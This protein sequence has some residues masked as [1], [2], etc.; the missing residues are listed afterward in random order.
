[1][2]RGNP[3]LWSTVMAIPFVIAGLWLYIGKTGY[4]STVGLP[5][6][7]FAIFISAVGTYV[8]YVGAPNQPE[9]QEGDELIVSRHPTQRVAL[10]KIV[11]SVPFLLL[12][13]YLFFYTIYPYVYPTVAFL[14]GLYLF[15]GG[16]HTYWTN[17]LT[18]Y[19]V[20]SERVI[21][22]YRLVSLVRQEVPLQKVRGV[23]ERKSVIET[24]VGLGNVRVASGEGRS[25]EIIMKDMGRSEQFASKVRNAVSAEQK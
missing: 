20:T 12:T 6:L 16:L 13:V 25:L 14:A 19:Y 9:L 23:Q 8:H 21:K 2:S 3:R 7:F 24:F 4:P 18:T 1:M 22:E 11:S 17:L 15:S 5:F 10:V